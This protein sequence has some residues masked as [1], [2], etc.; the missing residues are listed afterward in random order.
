MV[1]R[2]IAFALVLVMAVPFVACSGKNEFT[3][4]F[5]SASFT[6]SAAL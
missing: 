4:S 5:R 3:L 2:I 6:L 1:K